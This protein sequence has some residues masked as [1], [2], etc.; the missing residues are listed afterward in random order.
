MGVMAAI[1]LVRHGESEMNVVPHLSH[2]MA[3]LPLTERGQQ[4]ARL[5][6][7]R[8]AAHRLAGIVTSPLR[9]ARQ[10]ADAIADVTGGQIRVA[11]ALREINC[12]D[13]DGRSDA[14]AWT[15]TRAIYARWNRGERE[16]TFP[17][18]ES[19]R[20]LCARLAGV[21]REI[22]QAHPHEDVAVVGHGGLFWFAL[23][24]V[25]GLPL[26]AR[27]E[28]LNTSVTV[29]RHEG[30]AIACDL[31]GCITHLGPETAPRSHIV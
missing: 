6:A 8:L 12:G 29:L 19:H 27:T 7:A 1:Y 24:E 15:A 2:R 14:E 22:V 3:D 28:L 18:G 31:W 23:P 10:T 11:E 9:R 30:G 20:E 21:V 25:C 16:T 5:L 13:L 17:G 26:D 4:Q